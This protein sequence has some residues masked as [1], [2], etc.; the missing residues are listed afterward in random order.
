MSQKKKQAQRSLQLDIVTPDGLFFSEPVV[1]VD[2]PGWGGR[3][4][5]G[6]VQPCAAFARLQP[7]RLRYCSTLDEEKQSVW[8]G[9][10]F[11][12]IAANKVSVL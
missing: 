9:P 6:A 4:F 10:G 12:E 7:G 1:V 8:L 2:L 11:A 3:P 5:S